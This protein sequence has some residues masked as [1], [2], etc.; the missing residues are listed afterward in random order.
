MI[1]RLDVPRA[2]ILAGKAST[3]ADDL[4][5]ALKNPKPARESRAATRKI[6]RYQHGDRYRL[7]GQSAPT[8]WGPRASR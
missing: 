2:Q 7:T 4:L 3:L 1:R 5:L 6:Q 8:Q